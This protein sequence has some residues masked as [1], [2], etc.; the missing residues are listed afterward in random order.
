MDTTSAKTTVTEPAE[1]VVGLTIPECQ[2]LIRLQEESIKQ[3]RT[4]IATIRQHITS[5][6]RSG[7]K[8]DDPVVDLVYLL[9]ADPSNDKALFENL[10]NFSDALISRKGQCIVF[11]H[12]RRRD[13]IHTTFSDPECGRIPQ[14]AE[15]TF[16]VGILNTDNTFPLLYRAKGESGPQSDVRIQVLCDC[17]EE[18]EPMYLSMYVLAFGFLQEPNK[19]PRFGSLHDEPAEFSCGGSDG[20]RYYIGNEAV[21]ALLF[22]ITYNE[23]EH[24]RVLSKKIRQL[25]ERRQI[26]LAPDD[27]LAVELEP[28]ETPVEHAAT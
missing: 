22:R 19:Q 23:K 7:I 21:S 20:W 4:R 26:E 3:G 11:E 17:F 27:V 16:V 25:L 8:S 14:I 10:R 6:I 28:E 24:H 15:S 13:A 9:G 18:T 1:T 12:I 5:L 2:E